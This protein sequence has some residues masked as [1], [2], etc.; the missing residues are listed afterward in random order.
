VALLSEH[1]FTG[2]EIVEGCATPDTIY[3][4]VKV[5]PET[6]HVDC[7]LPETKLAPAATVIELVPWPEVIV[8]PV[9]TVQ[10]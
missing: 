4:A 1:K 9:G 3:E 8:K 6:T 2:P 7:I 10:V 5:T